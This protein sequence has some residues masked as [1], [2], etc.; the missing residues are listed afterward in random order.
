MIEIRY[1][2]ELYLEFWSA[3]TQSIY[4]SYFLNNAFSMSCS[5]LI[6]DEVFQSESV[7]YALYIKILFG[8]MCYVSSAWQVRNLKY[9]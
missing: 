9:P 3:Y 2:T 6:E 4:T 1:W 7:R 5:L 8:G